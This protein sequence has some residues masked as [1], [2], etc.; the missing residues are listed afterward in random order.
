MEKFL[1]IPTSFI[2]FNDDEV[3]NNKGGIR[4]LQVIPHLDHHLA[5]P[6]LAHL[7][8][9]SLFPTNEFIAAQYELAKG[10]TIFDYASTL[11][12]QI[13][14]GEK[15]PSGRVFFSACCANSNH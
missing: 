12:E 10:T 1:I 8:E 15:V 7:F 13:Y 5:F 14:P 3:D 4:P 6:L 11:F 9:T 2:V